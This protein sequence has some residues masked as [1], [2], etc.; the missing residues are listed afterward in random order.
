MLIQALSLVA[1]LALFLGGCGQAYTV[2]GGPA[3]FRTLGVT[4]ETKRAMTDPAVQVALDKKPLAGFPATIAIARV[5][6]SDYSSYDPATRTT[7]WHG[8]YS[9]IT[10]RTI[11]R[12]EDFEALQKLPQVNAVVTMK[13]ILLEHNA[14]S[15]AEL[16]AAAAKLHAD[17][18]LFYTFDT[19]FYTDTRVRPLSV[20][21]LGLFPNKSAHVTCTASAVLMDVN[22]GYLYCVVEATSQDQQLANAWSSSEAMDELRRRVERDAFEQL[23]KQFRQEW[24]VVV[25][26]YNRPTKSAVLR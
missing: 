20:I 5:Q 1:T 15:D 17:M 3:D 19:E 12:D 7:S 10:T 23:T 13:R 26:T 25:A 22:S 14:A 21:S 9:V 4:A 24:P 6:A 2:P 11:E 8:A 18:L 16:R